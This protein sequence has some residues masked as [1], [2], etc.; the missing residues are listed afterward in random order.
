M[1]DNIRKLGVVKRPTTPEKAQAEVI[2]ILEELL[3]Q[4]KGG[5]IAEICVVVANASREWDLLTS[6]TLS[7]SEWVGRLEIVQSDWIGQYKANR[8]KQ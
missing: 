3:E 5:H 4:A 6:S 1:S 7:I 8:D 2:E